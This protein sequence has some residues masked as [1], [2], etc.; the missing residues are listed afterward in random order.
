MSR[1][2]RGIRYVHSTKTGRTLATIAAVA[3]MLVVMLAFMTLE[4]Y[5]Y[6]K[7]LTR[8]AVYIGGATII[9]FALFGSAL[10]TGIIRDKGKKLD[11]HGLIF[12]Y[13]GTI[14]ITITQGFSMLFACCHDFDV[15]A[16]A[17]FTSTTIA[18]TVPII[19]G[20]AQIID[21]QQSGSKGSAD[22]QPTAQDSKP[23]DTDPKTKQG[24]GQPSAQ[25]C[26]S[27]DLQFRFRSGRATR[28]SPDGTASPGQP[29]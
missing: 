2:R 24:E 16:L 21:W 20:F 3:V 17:V 26:T 18:C 22:G 6:V 14:S 10:G 5:D 29:D 4:E 9:A 27:T 19:L 28:H 11:K 1:I 23:E 12:I 15:T 8:E 25:D 13:L 7:P